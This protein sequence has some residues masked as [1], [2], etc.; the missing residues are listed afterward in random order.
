MYGHTGVAAG[1]GTAGALATTGFNLV[2]LIVVGTMFVIGGALLM[3]Q[4]LGYGP[5]DKA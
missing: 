3:R 1:M 2:G 4:S 5:S